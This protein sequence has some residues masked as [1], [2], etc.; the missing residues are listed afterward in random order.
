MMDEMLVIFYLIE[1]E[2]PEFVKINEGFSNE[3]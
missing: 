2:L 1:A 3:E